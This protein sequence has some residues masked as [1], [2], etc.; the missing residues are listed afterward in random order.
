MPPWRNIPNN[1]MSP[2]VL[3]AAG[4][5]YRL[6]EFCGGSC[7]V[8]LNEIPMLPHRPAGS[9]ALRSAQDDIKGRSAKMG[10]VLE[11][12]KAFS[13]EGRQILRQCLREKESLLQWE[14]VAAVG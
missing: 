5:S 11:K 2:A 14:K 8:F 9:T 10:N 6:E 3:K 4:L 13:G 7:V 1:I 12:K